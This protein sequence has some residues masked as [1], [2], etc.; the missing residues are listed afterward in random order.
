[1]HLYLFHGKQCG[2]G[3]KVYNNFI[4][5]LMKII[6]KVTVPLMLINHVLTM[7]LRIYVVANLVTLTNAAISMTAVIL[8]TTVR[9]MM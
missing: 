1:M 8:M 7:K 6:I 5:L 3:K 4:L 9:L 2:A